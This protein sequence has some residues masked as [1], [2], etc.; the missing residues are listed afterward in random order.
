MAISET[1]GGKWCGILM[2]ALFSFTAF[3]MAQWGWVKALSFSPL[4]VGIIPRF[5]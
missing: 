2:M 3:Y 4:I 1:K 5:K